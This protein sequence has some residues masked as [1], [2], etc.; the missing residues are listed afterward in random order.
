MVLKAIEARETVS[1][2]DLVKIKG[3]KERVPKRVQ[4][5]VKNSIELQ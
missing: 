5:I 1:I 3:I 2:Q 4:K